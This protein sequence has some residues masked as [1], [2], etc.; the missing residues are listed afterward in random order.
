MD[1]NGSQLV[2]ML[3]TYMH[4]LVNEKD[5]VFRLIGVM[6]PVPA[7]LDAQKLEQT[8]LHRM[9]ESKLANQDIAKSAQRSDGYTDGQ[10]ILQKRHRS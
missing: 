3:E 9:S 5:I 10:S 2:G 6:L 7:L 8:S 1:I 4:Y